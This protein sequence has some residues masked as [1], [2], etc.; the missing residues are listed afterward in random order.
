MPI[1]SCIWDVSDKDFIKIVKDS[2][3]YSEV[4]RKVGY[5]C[6]TNHRVIKKRIKHLELDVSHLKKGILKEPEKKFP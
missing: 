5:K 4:A 6:T 1:K 2:I 3:F